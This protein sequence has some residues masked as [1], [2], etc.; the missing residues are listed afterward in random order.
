[1][2]SGIETYQTISYVYYASHCCMCTSVCMCANVKL[3]SKQANGQTDTNETRT[4]K[5]SIDSML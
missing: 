4:I 1:M 5:S 3:V 2:C